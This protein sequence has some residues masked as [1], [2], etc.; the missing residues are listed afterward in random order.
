MT[1]LDRVHTILHFIRFITLPLHVS[2]LLKSDRIV[3]D[4]FALLLGALGLGEVRFVG[5]WAGGF[6]FVDFFLKLV[7]FH[8]RFKF[9][10]LSCCK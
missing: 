7:F 9:S 3:D 8:S 2:A 6:P 4:T 1:D 5:K 10:L